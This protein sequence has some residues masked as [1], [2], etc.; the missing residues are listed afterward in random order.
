MQVFSIVA[1]AL[2]GFAL[3]FASFLVVPALVMIL[4][5]LGLYAYDEQRKRAS[6]RKA[7]AEKAPVVT[8]PP[9]PIDRAKI[10]RDAEARLTGTGEPR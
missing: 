8:G 10:M 3:M 9:A 7:E 6:Q 1:L 5:T 4:F 2:A